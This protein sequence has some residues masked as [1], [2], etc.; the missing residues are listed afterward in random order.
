M[1]FDITFD[2]NDPFSSNKNSQT[3]YYNIDKK[4]E[5]LD[6]LISFANT[7]L[8]LHEKSLAS[9]EKYGDKESFRAG[10]E[11]GAIS[12]LLKLKEFIKD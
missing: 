6:K 11:R 3:T 9:I 5:L 2:N 1:G 12:E 7:Q 4:R 10:F 8:S